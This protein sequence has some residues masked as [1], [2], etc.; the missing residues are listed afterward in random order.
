MVDDVPPKSVKTEVEAIVQLTPQQA[1]FGNL[2]TA[3][4]EGTEGSDVEPN[5]SSDFSL[6]SG[7]RW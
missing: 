4:A 6:L 5:S 3:N 7:F 2:F 1:G